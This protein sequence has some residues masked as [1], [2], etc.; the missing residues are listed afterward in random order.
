MDR[1]MIVLGGGLIHE[2]VLKNCNIDTDKYTGIAFG[3]GIERLSLLIHKINDI[4]LFSTNDIRFLK[5]FK[6]NYL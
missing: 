5:Q 3:G 2:N 6:L 1:R 4:R